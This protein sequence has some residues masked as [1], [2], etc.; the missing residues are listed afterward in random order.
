S[1]RS[2]TPSGP[3]PWPGAMGPAQPS[4]VTPIGRS[5]LTGSVARWPRQRSPIRFSL[6]LPG[7]FHVGLA[8]KP[9]HN[10]GR[11]PRV[12][13]SLR[14]P[15]TR[16]GP[17]LSI[18]TSSGGRLVF[19][20]VLAIVLAGGRGVRLDPLTRDR[21]KPAVPFGGIYRIIDFTLS[22]CINSDM[23]KVLVL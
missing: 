1:H 7:H 6:E 19:R 9:A 21:A 11:G 20:D 5:R 22:N 18:G 3:P 14:S 4:S 15:G 10:G 2:S 13:A 8:R 23:R 17:Q 16:V 12:E